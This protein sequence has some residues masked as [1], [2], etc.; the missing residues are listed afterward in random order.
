MPYLMPYAMLARASTFWCLRVFST[1]LLLLDVAI[2][3]GQRQESFE[4]FM[5]GIRANA[6]QGEVLFQRNEW[7][8]PLESGLKL[9]EGD[10]VR[11]SKGSYAELL[12]QPGNYLRVGGDTEFQ[13]FSEQ[14]DKMRLK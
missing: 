1:L 7:K 10:F 8:F 14:H 4:G 9:E 3:V 11:S 5:S 6:V 13:I 2:A 12:L